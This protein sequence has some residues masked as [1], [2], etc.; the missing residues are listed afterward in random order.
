MQQLPLSQKLNQVSEM[1]KA[2]VKSLEMI[3]D[4]LQ[5]N[6]ILGFFLFFFLF[7]F[8]HVSASF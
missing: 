8:E 2:A 1:A 5:G 7:F 3:E 4:V 6:S